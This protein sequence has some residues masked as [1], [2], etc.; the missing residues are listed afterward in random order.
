[1][2]DRTIEDLLREEYFELLPD[3][4]K[5]AEQLEAEIRFHTLPISRRLAK[6]EQ[7]RVRSRIKSCDSAV[8]SLRRRQEGQTFDSETPGAYSLSQLRDLVGVRVLAF[9]RSRLAEIDETLRKHFPLWAP[10]PVVDESGNLLAYKYYGRASEANENLACEYQIASML[11]GLFWE[12]EHATIYKP[13][14][15]LKGIA[16]SLE[17]KEQTESVYAALRGF[18]AEFERQLLSANQEPSQK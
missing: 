17:M 15:E 18:E 1:M 13:A 12:V 8:G 5:A 6:H 16:D 11:T 10:D 9:P 2:P 7:I 14:P 4:T 3:L